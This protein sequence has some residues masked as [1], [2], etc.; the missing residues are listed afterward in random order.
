MPEHV[1]MP[2]GEDHGGAT[3]F[4]LETHY[5][6][7]NLDKGVV[8]SSGLRILLTPNLRE[9][10]A[11]IMSAG[12]EVQPLALIVPPMQEEFTTLGR[13]TADCTGKV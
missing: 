11:G 6:N 12:I 1:G 10:D 3:F 4:I 9:Y 2:I 7:P 5:D 13:C 8:D